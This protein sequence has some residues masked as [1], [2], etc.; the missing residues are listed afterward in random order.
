[1]RRFFVKNIL[2]VIAVNVLVKPIWVLLID[3][4]VQ[5][6]VPC[7]EYGTYQAL[8]SL[9][10]IFQ[11]ILDM[12][13]SNYNSKT[14]AQNP[15][16]L[17]EI[18]PPMLSA[19]VVLMGLYMAVA[20]L[21]GLGL[22]YRGAELTLLLGVLLF[23]ALNSLLGFMRSNI[24]ALQRF[25][26]DGILSVADRLMMIII[27]GALLLNPYTAARFKI[28]WF[29]ATQVL[30][31]S[32]T[33]LVA[34]LVLRKIVG[35]K[36]RFSFKRKEV[37]S[38]IKQSLPYA[39]LIFQMSIY[40][41]ADAMM[42]ERICRS[43][44]EQADIWASAF[45]LL[46]MANM[47]GLMFA[48]MLLPVYGRMIGERQNVQPIVKLCANI[49]IP[50]SFIVVVGG[51]LFSADIMH[52]LYHGASGSMLN[53]YKVVFSWLIASFP[54]WCAMYIYSTLLTANGNMRKLN[55]IAFFGVVFNLILNA[56]LIPKYKAEGAA[57]T[58]FLTQTLLAG[59]F[60]VASYKQ[61]ALRKDNGWIVRLASYFVLLC[62]LAW[63]IHT[64]ILTSW[65]LQLTLISFT[66]GCL[67]LIFRFIS[68]K[69][70]KQFTNR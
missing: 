45:R 54:A 5:N 38:I 53:D 7:G 40:N 68:F 17:L 22:G 28:S 69:A 70:L 1:M 24:A 14:I 16:K 34:Y 42:L 27:C 20:Y 44:K 57:I 15:D 29:V 41:R 61:F 25:K 60:I 64:Y 43:E 65:I 58:S 2:F 32:I 19:R 66:G 46:D 12:G 56:L 36:L 21:W 8:L 48:S 6:K 33:A 37:V 49:L 39:L 10:I 67:I 55:S 23:Q 9:S 30:C 31:Y 35:S 18:F 4:S 26:T 13:I 63:V 50:A 59:M 51:V 52:L 62:L 11:I 47:F 3:R